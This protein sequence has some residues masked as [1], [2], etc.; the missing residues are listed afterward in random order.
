MTKTHARDPVL[1]PETLKTLKDKARQVRRLT[2][3]SIGH[4]GVGHVGGCMSVVEILTLLYYRHMNV[5]PARPGLEDRDKLVLSKGHA[6]PALYSVLADLG[7]FPTDWLDTLNRG[8]TRLPSH[9]DR[10]RTPGIDMSTGSLGQGLSAA[11]GIALGH[12]LDGIS[13]R[14]YAIIGDGD[15]NEGQTWEAAMTAAH[16]GLGS[17]IAFTDYNKLQIDGETRRIMN[18][19]RVEERWTAFGWHTQR[20]DGHDFPAMDSA[21]N[22]ARAQTDKPSMVILDTLKGKGA[23][24]C[25]GKVESHNMPVDDESIAEALRRLEDEED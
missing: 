7:F 4:L 6:G 13:A 10:I 22:N 9:C 11:E 1:D 3:R 23:F 24:F 2:L 17:L 25:E 20:V 16:Y 19:E 15:T 12:R 8:G 18:T 21:I 5:D 14:V